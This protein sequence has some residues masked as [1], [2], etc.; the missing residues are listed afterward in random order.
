M[1]KRPVVLSAN[2]RTICIQTP[3]GWTCGV[4]ARGDLGEHPQRGEECPRCGALVVNDK[5]TQ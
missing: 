4:C 3:D 5:E 2:I 1:V